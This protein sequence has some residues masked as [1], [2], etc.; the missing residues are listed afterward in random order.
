MLIN[1][2]LVL[3]YPGFDFNAEMIVADRLSDYRGCVGNYDNAVY[4]F[5]KDS[6][7]GSEI[8]KISEGG[9]VEHIPVAIPES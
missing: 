6:S 3:Y 7:S 4:L 9:N 2:D 5:T 1:R 8:L